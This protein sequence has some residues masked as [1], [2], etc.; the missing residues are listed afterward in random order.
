ML[1]A[2]LSWL[3]LKH[4]PDKDKHIQ[5]IIDKHAVVIQGLTDKQTAA[6]LGAP[7]NTYNHWIKGT[8]EPS[9]AVDRL[10]EVLTTLE[11]LAPDLLAALVPDMAPSRPRGRP[12]SKPAV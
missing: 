7:I 10:I 2:V 3:L 8:R 5:S 4:L 12:P 9:A 1:G 11:V 6:L